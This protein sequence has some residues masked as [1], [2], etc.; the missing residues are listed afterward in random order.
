[1]PQRRYLIFAVVAPALLMASIDGTIVAVGLSTILAE[2]HTTL[3]LVAWTITGFQLTQTVVMPMAGK[4]GDD[5]GRKR[6]FL[7]AVLVF[8]LGSVGAGL[9]PNVY[10]LI[11][12]RVLQALGG[13]AFLPAAVGI[14]SDA[15]GEQRQTALGLF[16]SI[17]PL[18]GVI[19]PNIGGFIIDHFSWRWIFFVNL[20]IG[21]LLLVAGFFILP[22]DK[23][24]EER[25]PVDALGAGFFGASIFGILYG[26]TYLA[27]HPG[28]AGQP[29]PWL[30]FGFG[31]VMLVLFLRHESRTPAPMIELDLLR[32][33]PL[34]A[35]NLYNFLYGASV[36]GFFAFI[37]YYATIAYG[38]TAGESGAIL[39]PRSIT[40]VLTSAVSSLFLI[41]FGYRLPMIGGLLLV[42]TSLLL[43]SQGF[44]NLSLFGFAVPNLVLLSLM[45]LVSG[46]GIGVS[47]PAAQNAAL[48]LIPEKLSVIAGL[49]GMFRSTGGV[50]GT[51]SVTLAL[52]QFSNKAQGLQYIF[53]ALAVT[54]LFIMPVVFM[55]PDTARQ[56]R[57]AAVT[58]DALV[59]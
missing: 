29:E 20:P 43:L 2:L 13:G 7:I 12:F 48:D 23:V 24:T 50:L 42:G 9:A 15:F 38:M 53:L 40:M 49:R 32:W 34:F 30:F 22:R 11:I 25:K 33:R 39:T 47:G 10:A 57:T 46:L 27:N 41:K 35:V 31:F 58:A 18:G 3:P 1:M 51:A 52:S 4:L 14:V 45:M 26:M 37:P 56:R 5:M 17:F 6:L 8:T 16:T 44:H 59:D 28:Q 19:G 55:I 36:F 21:L 54:M